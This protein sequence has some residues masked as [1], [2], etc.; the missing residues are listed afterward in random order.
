MLRLRRQ[1]RGEGRRHRPGAIRERGVGNQDEEGARA[2]GDAP[3]NL[4]QELVAAQS[5]ISD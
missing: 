4:V 1:R 5:L 2:R 3:P